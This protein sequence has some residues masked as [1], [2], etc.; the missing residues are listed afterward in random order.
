MKRKVIR[1]GCT[2]SPCS[3]GRGRNCTD[4]NGQI[5]VPIIDIAVG[6]YAV[7]ITFGDDWN[8]TEA[9]KLTV[10]VTINKITPDVN[11]APLTLVYG[12]EDGFNITL[13]YNGHPIKGNL[14]NVVLDRKGQGYIFDLNCTTDE[15]GTIG[16]LLDDLPADEYLVSMIYD[17]NENRVYYEEVETSEF[18][19]VSGV[20]NLGSEVNSG[21]YKLV[22]CVGNK[23]KVQQF[24]V[25]SY[26]EEK[27][28]IETTSFSL[29]ILAMLFMLCGG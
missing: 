14:V 4:E 20:F 21:L 15:N 19:I 11:L 18:G 9:A 23:E 25:D 17:G 22:V 13:S 10:N 2:E 24:K 16:I 12:D 7:N 28:K 6:S 5:H 3:G 29:H 1:N 8:Y 26:T 27:F